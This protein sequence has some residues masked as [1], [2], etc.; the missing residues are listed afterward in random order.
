MAPPPNPKLPPRPGGTPLGGMPPRRSWAV[1]L[2]ILL[3]N[4]WVFS[5]LLPGADE[6]VT[7]PYTT[8]REQ[9]AQDNVSAIYSQGTSIEGRFKSPVT[10]PPANAAGAGSAAPAPGVGPIASRAPSRTSATFTTELPTFFD[11]GLEDFLIRHGV[12]ISATPIRQGSGWATLLFGFGPALLIIAFYVWLWRRASAQGGMGGGG[13]FGIGRSKAKRYDIDKDTRVTFDDVAGIDE[14]E[15]ELVEIVDFLKSPQKYTRLGGTAPKGVLL[16]GSPGTGKTLLAK[17]VAGEA[18]VP[19]FSMSAAE[20]VEM[21]V[22]VGAARVRDLFKQARESA[23]AIIFIDEVDAIGRARGQAVLGGASEQEHTLQQILTEMDGFTGREGIIVLAATNQP[24]VL[25]RALLRPGRFDRRVVVNLPDKAG[26]RAILDVHVRK[27]PLAA[28]ANL[29]ELAQAT[30]GFSGADLKNL[31]NEAALLAARRGE[32]AVQQKDFL[33]SLEKIV[34]GPE[35]PL[36]LS[37]EDRERIA[38]HESGHAILGLLVPGADPVHR[39]SIVPRG[40]ALGVT[41]QRPSA[42]RYNYPEDYLRARIIGMLGGRAAEEVVYGT[43][44]TGAENDIEQATQLARN[45]VTRWGMSDAVGMVQLAPRQNA[46]LGGPAGFGGDRPFSEQTASLIDAE[47][48]R[49]I[50]ECH[51]QA[52]RLLHQHRKALDALVASLLRQETLSEHEILQAT[53]LQPAP[54]LHG[55]PMV[56]NAASQA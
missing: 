43:R 24:D 56:P 36:L 1:F 54:Q 20:F 49:I 51:V 25:D 31:V 15:A 48:Q 21:I 33:D 7:V 44:T 29:E 9:V 3:I 40:Q 14:A 30:P 12:E 37:A 19:F 41:Y 16:V 22:G 2:V 50:N 18:G 26:R 8:F 53:G 5:Q 45:M 23:P 52:K 35:R 39:V 17:A 34:L 6:P 47:V 55:R 27:V 46:F 32:A 42:D 10:W 11:R 13:L 38:Y 4:Y 28:D